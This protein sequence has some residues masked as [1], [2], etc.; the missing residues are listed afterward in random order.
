MNSIIDRGVLGSEKLPIVS[1]GMIYTSSIDS[2]C[3][4]TDIGKLTSLFFFI[5]ASR[6]GQRDRVQIFFSPESELV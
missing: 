5:G 3:R 1:I 6:D 2:L 4:N